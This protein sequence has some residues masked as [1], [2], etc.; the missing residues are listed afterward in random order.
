MKEDKIVYLTDIRDELQSFCPDEDPT[1]AFIA[2]WEWWADYCVRHKMRTY[3][4]FYGAMERGWIAR[5]DAES[6]CLFLHNGR[7]WRCLQ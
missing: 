5:T 3:Q 7:F 1:G 2:G 6:L 4:F